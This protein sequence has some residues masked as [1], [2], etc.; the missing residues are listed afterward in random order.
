MIIMMMMMM[1]MM[2]WLPLV[3]LIVMMM[4]FWLPLVHRSTSVVH[5][6][7]LMVQCVWSILLTMA[8]PGRQWSVTV[9][10]LTSLCH[11]VLTWS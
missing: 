9:L 3:M 8:Q 6:H 11:H 2:F 10:Q 1:M 7:R 4:K 5:R